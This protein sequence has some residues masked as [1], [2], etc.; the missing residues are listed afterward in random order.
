MIKDNIQLISEMA[1][2]DIDVNKHLNL[3]ECQ[4][5]ARKIDLFYE[6]FEEVIDMID[7]A[8]QQ[9]NNL[10]QGQIQR[11]ENKELKNEMRLIS[12]DY[13]KLRSKVFNFLLNFRKSQ[14]NR[15]SILLEN[16]A[17]V[18]QSETSYTSK[19]ISSDIFKNLVMD[20]ASKD[21]EEQ[22]GK[23]SP[24]VAKDNGNVKNLVN[25]N[26][27]K[28][29]SYMR[30]HNYNNYNSNEERMTYKSSQDD[31]MYAER[32][33]MRHGVFTDRNELKNEPT[34]AEIDQIFSPKQPKEPKVVEGIKV[35]MEKKLRVHEK[36]NKIDEDF[37]QLV[38]KT[39]NECTRFSNLL[40]KKDSRE[41]R[42]KSK[43]LRK[44]K[45]RVRS[46]SPNSFKVFQRQG[47]YQ[48]PLLRKTDISSETEK[49]K[50]KNPIDLK[51]KFKVSGLSYENRNTV[52]GDKTQRK[53][54]LKNKKSKIE[55]KIDNIVKTRRS[56]V[57]DKQQSYYY[58][59]IQRK[60]QR[61]SRTMVSANSDRRIKSGINTSSSRVLNVNGKLSL[62]RG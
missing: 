42:A 5:K 7:K 38:F 54:V 4:E 53:R 23:E 60:N 50:S 31:R 39:T 56:T 25:Q 36:I 45:K 44:I 15:D 20:I 9:F 17:A 58:N 27:G 55:Q 48:N 6:K 40:S 30:L 43:N 11:L 51:E 28:M 61:S 3:I 62:K 57:E 10:L 49:M 14:H 29:K 34:V 59:Y 41:S 12:K 32:M 37:T 2:A 16:E 18:D 13:E 22:G 24:G 21:T 52:G 46:L 47:L 8:K 1:I 33:L 26:K 35:F 19:T